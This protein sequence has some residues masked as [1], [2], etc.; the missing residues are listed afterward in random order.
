MPK[1]PQIQDEELHNHVMRVHRRWAGDSA[2]DFEEALETVTKLAESK[3]TGEQVT[4]TEWYPGENIEKVLNTLTATENSESDQPPTND[5]LQL[6]GQESSDQFRVNL[7]TQ[8]VFKTILSE[9]GKIDVPD[10]EL[11]AFDIDDGEVMQVIVTPF[12]RDDGA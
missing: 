8:M 5:S 11:K 6:Q 7:D 9:D 10:A 2:S 3:L 4:E 1:R 12:E